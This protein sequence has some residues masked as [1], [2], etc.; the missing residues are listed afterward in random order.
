MLHPELFEQIPVFGQ[1]AANKIN[2]QAENI[3]EE[4]TGNSPDISIAIR[5]LNEAEPIEK[6]LQDIDSQD[7]D[8]EVETIVVDNESTDRTS[9]VAQYYGAEV[10]SLARDGF[11]H[12][13]S[14]NLG[15]EAASHNL[16]VLTVGHALLS[17]DQALTG[18]ARHF[19]REQ[20]V[21]GVYAHALP[22]AN[23]SKT[24]KVLSIGNILFLE[25]PKKVMKA[26]L[27]VLAAT[28][29]MISKEAWE[30]LGRFDERYQTGGED[31]ALAGKMMDEGYAVFEEPTLSVHHTHGLGPVNYARQFQRWTKSVKGP[32]V[33]D[34]EK[35]LKS[36][37]D[38]DAR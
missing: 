14:M 12:P 19:S 33:L 5:A 2:S 20:L 32:Q 37:P 34:L 21:G 13:K 35:Y 8:G 29:A 18:S 38:L 24:E 23:A 30:E 10:V 16:V 6:L 17:N 36:R 9:E 3:A 15:V 7:Y 4:S 11:T 25:K 31:T 22:N 26:G 28:G 27:G 1:M